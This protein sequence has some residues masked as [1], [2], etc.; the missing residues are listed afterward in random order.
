M[1]NNLKSNK[2]ILRSDGYYPVYHS[3]YETFEL[4]EEF[5]DPGFIIHQSMARFLAVLIDQF[6]TRLIVPLR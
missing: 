3:V 2:L 6:A 1:Q 4:V 5:V